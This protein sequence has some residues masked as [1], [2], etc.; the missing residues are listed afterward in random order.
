LYG[1]RGARAAPRGLEMFLWFWNGFRG[2]VWFE[3]GF[4]SPWATY[5]F[6]FICD[7]I[8]RAEA[9]C[10][11]RAHITWPHNLFSNRTCTFSLT[12]GVA[13]QFAANSFLAQGIL[14]MRDAPRGCIPIV[15]KA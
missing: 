5:C 3:S 15:P 14:P 2:F 11:L 9:Y 6:L 12:Q 13:E 7:C 10:T 8:S 4:L 1:Y